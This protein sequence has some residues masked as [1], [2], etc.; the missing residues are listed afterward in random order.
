MTVQEAYEAHMAAI[1]ST[2]LSPREKADAVASTRLAL[3]EAKQA[4]DAPKRI[5][6]SRRRSA[7][8]A[9]RKF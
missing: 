1:R 3:Q 4:A 5:E 2:S 9:G 6:I 7:R 8:V